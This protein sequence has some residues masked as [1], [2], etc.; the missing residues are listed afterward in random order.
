LD[1]DDAPT[2][3]MCGQLDTTQGRL[4]IDL[5]FEMGILHNAKD[6]ES[7]PTDLNVTLTLECQSLDHESHPD[8]MVQNPP[9]QMRV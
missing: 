2:A 1:S 9:N 5:N 3:C 4:Y 8:P 6:I 7:L